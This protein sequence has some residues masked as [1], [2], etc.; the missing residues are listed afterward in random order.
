MF[1]TVAIVGVGMIGGSIGLAI[2]KKKI[3]R[4]VIGIGHRRKSIQTAL[5]Y[6][7]IDEG[8]LDLRKI[9][10]AD[11]VI[12]ACPVSR[13]IEILRKVS[14][15][16]RPGALVIDVGS[17]KSEI[18]KTA[19]KSKIEFIGSHPLAG[20]EK[21]GVASAKGD[22]FEGSLCLVTPLKNTRPA[23]INKIR[24]FWH[25]LGAR[26]QVMDASTHDRILAYVSHL[27]HAVIFGLI[28]CVEAR[29]L[30]F[31]A[32]GLKDTTRIGLS[33]PLLWRDIFLTNRQELLGAIKGF[34]RSLARLESLISNNQP[35]ALASY[36]QKSRNKRN[37]F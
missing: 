8:F 10:E 2:K 35:K 30:Q 13:I 31:G 36:L 33:E 20:M 21:T 25:A 5:K 15:Y 4:R 6:K 7:S 26:T 27:P 16:A 12:L 23:L 29:Y 28:D 11:L 32:G 22:I 18:I 17:T 34:N 3:A 1:D 37:G 19:Q 9:K 24:R 14:R